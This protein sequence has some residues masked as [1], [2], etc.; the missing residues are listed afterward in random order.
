[1]KDNKGYSLIEFI[2]VIAIMVILISSVTIGVSSAVGWK[3]RKC[4]VAI[5]DKITDT[6]T[7]A[8]GKDSYELVLTY[9]SASG[10][11]TQ[12]SVFYYEQDPTTGLLE[13]KA[14][15]ET[16]ETTLVG[17]KELTVKAYVKSLKTAYEEEID[18]STTNL[19]ISFDRSSG[20]FQPVKKGAAAGYM[21]NPAD[22]N[23]RIYLDHID[24]V[25]KNGK[26]YTIRCVPITGKHFVED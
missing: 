21:V 2:F 10:F 17:D 5:N 16:T 23:D 9:D 4:A 12:S 8:L 13:L 22:I 25:A 20:K 18:I 19:T 14:V 1:M 15:A 3:A 24:V 6:K 26:T 11:M 7:N